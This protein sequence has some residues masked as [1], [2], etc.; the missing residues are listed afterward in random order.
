MSPRANNGE[1]IREHIYAVLTVA[2]FAYLY[3]IATRFDLELGI[4]ELQLEVQGSRGIILAG[5][6]CVVAALVFWIHMF[7]DF[8]R[9]RPARHAFAWGA[10]LLIAAHLAALVYFVAIWRPRRRDVRR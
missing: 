5:T 3:W 1:W 2:S 7:R 8:I 6:A 10:F 9:D 4:E